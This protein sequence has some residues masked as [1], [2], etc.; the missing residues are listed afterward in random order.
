MR[1]KG[2]SRLELTLAQWNRVVAQ[3]KKRT[4][5]KQKSRRAKAAQPKELSYIG[6]ERDTPS[7]N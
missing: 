1:R 2:Y 3:F 6:H 7:A 4:Q 5:P